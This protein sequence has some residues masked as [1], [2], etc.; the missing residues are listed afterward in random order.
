M[1][2]LPILGRL[3][4]IAVVTAT[5]EVAGPGFGPISGSARNRSVFGIGGFESRI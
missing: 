3:A 4:A 5:H 1:L 2:C